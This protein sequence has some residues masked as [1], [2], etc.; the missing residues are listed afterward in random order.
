MHKL[1][2]A[3]TITPI[4]KAAIDKARARVHELQNL[5]ARSEPLREIRSYES[6]SPSCRLQRDRDAAFHAFEQDPTPELME[7]AHAALIRLRDAH[8]SHG[9]FARILTA[10]IQRESHSLAPITAGII[11]QALT[12]LETRRQTALSAASKGDSVL[13]DVTGTINA[14]ADQ[15]ARQL[16]NE[17]AESQSDPLGWLN[18]HDLATDHEA[19]PEPAKPTPPPVKSYRGKI[20]L[21]KA[22]PEPEPAGDVLSELA[23][24]DDDD[25][26]DPFDLLAGGN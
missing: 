14:R 26:A 10:A 13:A 17:R 8:E 4:D 15:L 19:E 24:D 18:G 7:A 22:E 6:R 5:G 21:D 11:D 2:S 1:L 23:D 3:V 9:H 12:A 16:E 20:R 25:N